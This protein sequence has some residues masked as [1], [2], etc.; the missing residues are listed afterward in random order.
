[1]PLK[2][3]L[4]AGGAVAAVLAAAIV[5][6]LVMHTRPPAGSG[7]AADS[8]T[9]T[10]L[11][12]GMEWTDSSEGRARL[13]LDDQGVLRLATA[14]PPASSPLNKAARAVTSALTT[15]KSRAAAARRAAAATWR[16]GGARAGWTERWTSADGVADTGADAGE[17]VE[18]ARP[19]GQAQVAAISAG[20]GRGLWVRGD[21]FTLGHGPWLPMGWNPLCGGQPLAS[22]AGNGDVW[23]SG[24][25]GTAVARTL[26]PSASGRYRAR[27][28]RNGDLQVWDAQEEEAVWTASGATG[29]GSLPSASGCTAE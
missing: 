4:L 20:S 27:L 3:T 16:I 23:W 24:S 9:V 11:A 8:A 7:G 19:R 2:D 26:F 10:W 12:D 21:W 25:E 15:R 5:L 28:L 6:V 17:A 14:D 18:G 1:M 29:E 13:M 22:A